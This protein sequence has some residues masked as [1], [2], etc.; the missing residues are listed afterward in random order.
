MRFNRVLILL[1]MCVSSVFVNANSI[2]DM[3]RSGGTPQL[4]KMK[5]TDVVKMYRASSHARALEAQKRAYAPSARAN[6]RTF[7]NGSSRRGKE[8]TIPPYIIFNKT[9]DL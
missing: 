1:T 2:M 3:Y 9:F 5:Q 6:K 4:R 8:F 7:D